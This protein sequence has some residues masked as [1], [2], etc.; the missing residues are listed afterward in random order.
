MRV[1]PFLLLVCALFLSWSRPARASSTLIVQMRSDMSASEFATVRVTVSGA[2]ECGS[3]WHA[4]MTASAHRD[5][6][7]GVRVA[8]L[9]RMKNGVAHAVVS[10]FDRTGRLLVE[11]SVRIILKGG[12]RVVTVLLTRPSWCKGRC[13]NK[14]A[15]PSFHKLDLEIRTGSDD[16]RGGNGNVDVV[17]GFTDG[18][19]QTFKNVNQGHRWRNHCLKHVRLPLARRVKASQ[20]AYVRLVTHFGGGMGGDNWNVDSLAVQN[21]YRGVLMYSRHGNPLFRLT[22]RR[23]TFLARW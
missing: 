12:V 5:W 10:A 19:T 15:A 17:V 22:G 21:D 4:L 3:S 1:A 9:P 20:I 11:R 13:S 8:E 7:R 16:L 6:K 18:L 2:D 14:G 23:H